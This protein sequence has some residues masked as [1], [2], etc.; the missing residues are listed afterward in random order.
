MLDRYRFR[1]AKCDIK[2]SDSYFMPP[3]SS[4]SGETKE[5]ILKIIL[6]TF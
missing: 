2:N 5:D 6:C 4:W 1:K 3:F